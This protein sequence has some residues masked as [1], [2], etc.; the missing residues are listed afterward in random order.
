MQLPKQPL[1]VCS[2]PE[3]V[4][5]SQTPQ[6]CEHL[7]DQPSLKPSDETSVS[8][9]TTVLLIIFAYRGEWSLWGGDNWKYLPERKCRGKK[10]GETETGKKVRRRKET[11]EGRD[12]KVRGSGGY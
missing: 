3:T 5:E 10:R 11:A 9:L 6:S 4:A 12:T 1:A 2:Q 8:T 7:M